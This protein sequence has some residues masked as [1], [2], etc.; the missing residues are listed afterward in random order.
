MDYILGENEKKDYEEL[1]NKCK[2]R[3]SEFDEKLLYLAFN[4]CI[5]AHAGK[6]RK[7]G[8]K[9]YTHPLAVAFILLDEI[10]LDLESVIA[11]LLHNVLDESDVYSYEDISFVFGQNIAAIVEG[12]TRIKF[13]ESQHIDRPD[14]LDNYRKLLLTLFTD[15]RIILV[16]LAD[17]LDNMRT[18]QY[19][20]TES[21]LKF[22][23][24]TLDIYIPFA[25]RFGLT[26]IKFELE[27]I[28]FKYLRP[29]LYKEIE[30][31]IK[32]T[33][34]SRT[35]YVNKFKEPI[36]R[37]LEEETLLK[38]YNVTYRID[39]RA[40]NI[41]SIYNKTLIRK[42]PVNELYDIFAIRIILDTNNPFLCDYVYGIVGSLYKP[43][44]ETFKDYISA[45]KPNGYSSLHTAVAGPDDKI[46]EVQIRTTQMHQASEEG[47]A[48]H[49]RY[50]SSV[51]GATILEDTQVQKWLDE[52]Q[53]IFK[54]VGKEDSNKLLSLILQTRL[55]DKIYVFTPQDEFRELPSGATVLDFAFNIHTDMGFQ[56]LGA[57]VNGKFCLVNHKLNS[58][59][60][61]E[62]ITSNKQKPEKEWLDY[63]VTPRATTKL[64]EYLK[65]ESN[66]T[67]NRGKQL[68][69]D[70]NIKHNFS[71][72]E[73]DFADML[74]KYNF[75]DAADFYIAIGNGS[76]NLDAIYPIIMSNM[77]MNIIDK[78]YE[79]QPNML[80][81]FT[82]LDSYKDK[83]FMFSDC[84]NPL[85]GDS[86]FGIKI[87]YNQIEVHNSY[88]Q[89]HKKILDI[90]QPDIVLLDWEYFNDKDFYAKLFITA[91][92]SNEII[93]KIISTINSPHT[94]NHPPET[95]KNNQIYNI[96]CDY[97]NG[98]ININIRFGIA[99]N[100][101]IK[102][103]TD[104]IASISEVRLVERIR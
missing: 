21:Q 46:V 96:D 80:E 56:C 61:V 77:T 95:T 75:D 31:A 30:D 79:S 19:V 64:I 37:R 1:L 33:H 97:I 3:F 72:N 49:F 25:N 27:D 55:A 63:V 8:L 70:K 2:N 90:Q 34:K 9:Y 69:E 88:C 4:Y 10:P 36:V 45:P 14:Q 65:K 23:Q 68:W 58:G 5:L 57:K 98:I 15:I 39:G 67:L 104:S 102:S 28:S 40:K 43:I 41:Y 22:S 20:S 71:A 92:E 35:E 24:E 99:N 91:N 85:P 7:S 60:R 74:K 50:K 12:I 54:S 13:V 11:A 16:K 89:K 51:N 78:V 93:D 66:T 38:H 17:R 59:D 87:S 100:Y 26:R 53:H 103:I 18:L 73:E 86:I 29:D 42:K 32:G 94:D 84:C 81:V 62:V 76:L 6:Y 82:H 101:F 83:E 47:I 48:A 44:P 52:V